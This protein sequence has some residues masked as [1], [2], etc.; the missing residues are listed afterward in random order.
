MLRRQLS[1]LKQNFIAL[2]AVAY[3]PSSMFVGFKRD[4]QTRTGVT[5]DQA[6]QFAV[7]IM[8]NDKRPSPWETMQWFQSTFNKHLD[9][10]LCENLVDAMIEEA[11]MAHHQNLKGKSGG[12]ELRLPGFG[13]PL[14][15]MPKR[16]NNEAPSA[17]FPVLGSEEEGWKATTLLIREVCMMGAVEELTNKTEWWRKCRD[18]E[19]AQKWKQ[20]A[21]AM[22]WETVRDHAD[23]TPAMFDA[24]LEELRHKADIYEQTGLIPVMDY[25]IATLKSDKLLTDELVT[26]LK[27]AVAPLENVPED[28]K[29]WHPGSHHQVLDLVHP[30]LWPLVYGKTR[31]LPNERVGVEDALDRCGSGVIIPE[32]L[33]LELKQGG[34]FSTRF[35]WLPSEVSITPDGKAKIDSYVNNLHPTEHAALYPILNRLIEKALPAW[36]VLYRWPEE[37]DT[38]RL[39]TTFAGVKCTTPELC[40]PNYMCMPAARPLNEGEEPRVEDEEYEDDYEESERGKLDMAWFQ[41]THEMDLPDPDP[42]KLPVLI[43]PKDIRTSGFFDSIPRIQVIVKLANI[44][45]TPESPTYEGGSWHIEGLQNEHICATALYYYDSYNVTDSH[46]DFRT[47]ANREGL[48]FNVRYDQGDEYALPR[49]FSLDCGPGDSG[50]P[51]SAVQHVG[52]ILTRPGRALFFPNL[53]QHRVSPFRLIDPSKPG[54]RKIV[55]LFL[56][57]PKIPIISTANVPP[58]RQDWWKGTE[59]PEVPVSKLPSELREMV[60]NEV[61]F[62]YGMKE[63]ESIREEFMKERGARVKEFDTQ[64]TSV[65]YSFC[66]H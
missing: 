45:L 50:S 42:T 13:L 43:G 38:Q 51:S 15:Y 39:K 18:P 4:L 24:V 59:Q 5:D 41:S 52:S 56:V 64:L 12:S 63:A 17:H 32:A 10:N 8:S 53:F 40:K 44:H 3:R 58:Q 25:C 19:I 33:P 21:L 23:F 36:D 35:Q 28:Q 54:H 2:S 48:A 11:V 31:I 27:A 16:E 46:L 1:L 61:D 20:E 65:E 14:S 30:S 66:E 6:A 47:R 9:I 49:T 22:D 29:D 7:W 60:V 55:A 26:E 37:F 62:P 57:D 34:Y